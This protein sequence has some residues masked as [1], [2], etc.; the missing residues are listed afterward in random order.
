MATKKKCS[1][2]P[3]IKHSAPVV[4]LLLALAPEEKP[5]GYVGSTINIARRLVEHAEKPRE[6]RCSWELWNW[7]RDRG[8][9]ILVK[10]LDQAEDGDHASLLEGLWTTVILNAGVVL[11]AVE[12]WRTGRNKSVEFLSG[13][14]NS[15]L[16]TIKELS[17]AEP[18]IDIISGNSEL[19]IPERR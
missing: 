9:P 10:I 1:K 7:A 15:V 14:S 4:Y 8:T 13:K 5:R 11:P 12:R 19:I 16:S 3:S 18:I 6:G 2:R 17:D